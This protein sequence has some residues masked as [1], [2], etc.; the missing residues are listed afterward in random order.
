M[1]MELEPSKNPCATLSIMRLYLYESV[2]I[3]M[4]RCGTVL[5]YKTKWVLCS[6]LLI[7]SVASFK[8]SITKPTTLV[9]TFPVL[10]IF[11]I[12][13]LSRTDL[14]FQ[15]FPLVFLML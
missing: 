15:T 8:F 7:K 6:Y 2:E 9:N 4:R 1:N 13:V 11:P 14:Y 12:L 5:P 3:D 10:I